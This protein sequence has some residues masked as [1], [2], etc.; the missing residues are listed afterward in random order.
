MYPSRIQSLQARANSRRT[1]SAKLADWTTSR[2]GTIWFLIGNLVFFLLWLCSNLGWISF[3]PAFDPYPFVLL[4]TV[5][6]LE[7]IFLAIV[8]LI[9]QNRAA[10]VADIREETDLQLDLI[11]EREITK[12]L[13][14]VTYLAQKQGLDTEQDKE[15]QRMLKELDVTTIE[16]RLEKQLNGSTGR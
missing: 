10:H 9:S 7:A 4:T 12:V 11:T 5:V 3:L 6:S 2:F 16:E 1:V 14:L 8:V 13:A 15:L